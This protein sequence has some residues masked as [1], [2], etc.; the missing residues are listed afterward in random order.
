MSKNRNRVGAGVTV[1]MLE[2][3]SRA[4]LLSYLHALEVKKKK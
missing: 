4:H 3:K 1:R 2:F